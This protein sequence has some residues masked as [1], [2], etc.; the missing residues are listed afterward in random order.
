MP[1]RLRR[2]KCF[3]CTCHGPPIQPASP[4]ESHSRKERVKGQLYVESIIWMP[5]PEDT[6]TLRL[7]APT[8]VDTSYAFEQS[9]VILLY[10]KSVQFCFLRPLRVSDVF[11]FL[12]NSPAF[13]EQENPLFL[14]GSCL[15]QAAERLRKMESAPKRPY[16]APFQ[17]GVWV[18]HY[19]K[20]HKAR[21]RAPKRVHID[22]IV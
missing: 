22:L 4:F 16:F 2:R 21:N 7:P 18:G 1:M 12:L 8:R 11:F 6:R 9:N 10:H 14:F 5:P 15:N 17:R 20:R 19:G 13:F 3:R